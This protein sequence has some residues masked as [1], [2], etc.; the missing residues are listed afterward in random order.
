VVSGS[1]VSKGL[2][3]S[4]K[5]RLKGIEATV[6]NHS[7]VNHS[8]FAQIAKWIEESGSRVVTVEDHQLTGGMGAQ[9]I[10]QLKLKGLEFD[11]V[12]LAVKGEFGQSAYSAD[13]LYAKHHLDSSA[14]IDAVSTLQSKGSFM[15]FDTEVLRTK[16]KDIS[17]E[18]RKKWDSISEKDLEKV[19]GNAT[20]MVSLVQEKFGISKEDASKKVEELLAKYPKDEIKAK[21]GET[22]M[23]ALGTANTIFDQVKNRIK[24]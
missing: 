7:F 8:D 23:K 9:L 19:K 6:I 15:N 1:L 22:A 21:V 14:I 17:Q 4:E 3:A 12:S 20:L 24:K 10:H 11:V 2:E 13:E 16:W 18:A 5:L